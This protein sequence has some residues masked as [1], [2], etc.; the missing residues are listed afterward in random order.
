MSCGCSGRLARRTRHLLGW[1]VAGQRGGSPSRGAL[2]CRAVNQG[3]P[4]GVHYREGNR[5]HL[6]W[7]RPETDAGARCR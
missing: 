1:L 6:G 4:P 2:F 7:R 3:R 5:A